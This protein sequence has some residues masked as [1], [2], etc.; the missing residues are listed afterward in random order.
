MFQLSDDETRNDVVDVA[1]VVDVADVDDVAGVVNVA[2]VDVIDVVVDTRC[3][4]DRLVS[5]LQFV[6][7]SPI[8]SFK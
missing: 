7:K 2:D 3:R 4:S 6:H 1:G 5:Q 8:E